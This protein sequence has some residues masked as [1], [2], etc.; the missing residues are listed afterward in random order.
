MR[1]KISKAGMP[2]CRMQPR[3]S[4]PKGG[5]F[6]SSPQLF[7]F[8]DADENHFKKNPQT[9]NF[10]YSP[11][12]RY[13]RRL[14]PLTAGISILTSF[15]KAQSTPH[16]PPL[17]LAD[18]HIQHPTRAAFAGRTHHDFFA[19]AVETKSMLPSRI[20]SSDKV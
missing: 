12:T 14:L 4:Y 16:A 8:N 17:H 5:N 10:F 3:S 13:A 18:L 19:T 9:Y 1:P 15:Q 20:R 7:Y 6:T 11:S 2:S